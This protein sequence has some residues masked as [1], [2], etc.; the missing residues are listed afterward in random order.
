M[1]KLTLTTDELGIDVVDR[2]TAIAQAFKVDVE[3]IGLDGYPVAYC[4][5]KLVDPTPQPLP[6]PIPAFQFQPTPVAPP[7]EVV[8]APESEPQT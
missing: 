6:D 3:A 8:P 7:V 2:V 4:P 5:A 1:L